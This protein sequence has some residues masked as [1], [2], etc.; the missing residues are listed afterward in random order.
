MP[1]IEVMN[2]KFNLDSNAV[3]AA[4]YAALCDIPRGKRSSVVKELLHAA[5][6]VGEAASLQSTEKIVSLPK[7][8]DK[9]DHEVMHGSQ[10]SHP[11]PYSASH[12]SIRKPQS[13][14]MEEKQNST[15]A[16]V[17]NRDARMKGDTEELDEFRSLIY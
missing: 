10:H 9:P 16:D 14:Q 5:L 17:D 3:D 6:C 7:R 15:S 12:T 1:R 2:I 8:R 4:V 13:E 11:L